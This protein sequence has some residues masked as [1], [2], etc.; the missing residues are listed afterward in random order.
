M[1]G[2][3]WTKGAGPLL[4]ADRVAT[5]AQVLERDLGFEAQSDSEARDE[6]SQNMPADYVDAF[7]RFRANGELDESEVFPTVT[8]VTGRQPQTFEAWARTHATA[9]K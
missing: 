5:L 8:E 7:M 2:A 1:D 4:P 9:F 6:M 3:T